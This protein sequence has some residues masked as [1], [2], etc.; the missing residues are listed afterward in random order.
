MQSPPL[1]TPRRRPSLPQPPVDDDVLITGEEIVISD[2]DEDVEE[3]LPT[4]P[5]V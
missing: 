3:G 1:P 5:D 4:V 2:D